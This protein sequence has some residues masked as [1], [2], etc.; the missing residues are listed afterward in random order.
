MKTVPALVARFT[1][2]DQLRF[3]QASPQLFSVADV[4][5]VVTALPTRL[6]RPGTAFSPHLFHR[7]QRI[8]TDGDS[9]TARQE[10][11]RP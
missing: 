9:L 6:Q 5:G 4:D 7:A 10:H 11:Q 8:A 3:N 2:T 1:A